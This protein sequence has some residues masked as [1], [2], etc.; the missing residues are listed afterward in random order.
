MRIVHTLFRICSFVSIVHDSIFH[1]INECLLRTDGLLNCRDEERAKV[2]TKER[3]YLVC[4]MKT[5]VADGS[6]ADS[7]NLMKMHV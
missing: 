3:T 6:A 4:L 5:Q 7:T 1:R 2:L